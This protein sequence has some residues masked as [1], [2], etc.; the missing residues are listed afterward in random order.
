MP[1]DNQLIMQK[2]NELLQSLSERLTTVETKV[3]QLERPQLM[4]KPPQCQDYQTIAE[5]LDDLHNAVEE[6]R[7]VGR[8][9][10]SSDD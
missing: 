1:L 3:S 7:N 5:T 10:Q 4:Y 9:R 8:D 2:Y 6:L